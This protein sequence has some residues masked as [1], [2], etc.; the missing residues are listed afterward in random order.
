MWNS[1]TRPKC[2]ISDDDSPGDDFLATLAQQ[3][4]GD[5]SPK[6]AAKR[7]LDETDRQTCPMC[8][9]SFYDFRKAGRLGCAYDYTAFRA[10][11]E[12][13]VMNIHGEI[14][15]TGKHPRTQCHGE[16]VERLRLVRLRRELQE[17]IAIE[18]A[19]DGWWG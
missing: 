10:E 19:S 14:E 11:L 18:R 9:I 17:A 4:A 15:H 16:A 8:G 7:E 13:L 6:V 5:L 3:F 2:R 1:L 12:P